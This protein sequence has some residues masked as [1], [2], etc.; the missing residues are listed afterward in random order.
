[1]QYPGRR[2]RKRIRTTWE[3]GLW[4]RKAIIWQRNNGTTKENGD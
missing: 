2:K 4:Y 1:M 3:M